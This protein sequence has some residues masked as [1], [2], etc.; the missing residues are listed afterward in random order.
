MA[1]EDRGQAPLS[2]FSDRNLKCVILC[3]G[4]GTRLLPISLEKQKGMI[5]LKEKP[6]IQHIIDYWS[7]FTDEFIFVVK[8]KK[9]EIMEY[10]GKTRLKAGFVEPPELRGI[11]DGIYQV[12]DLISDR[13]IVVLGDCIC[14]GEF[15]FP[16]YMEQGAGVWKTER[17]EDIKRSYSVLLKNGVIGGLEEKPKSPP[18]DLCG[19][20]FYFLDKRVFGYIE[21]TKPSSLRGEVE[22][23]DVIQNMISA[24]ERLSPVHFRGDYLN[25]TYAGDLELA[26]K[27]L[28]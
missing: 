16:D 24:G 13:F 6:I 1:I 10:V 15:I 18:N 26:L 4:K 14:K 23:T 17:V 3:G 11:A 22:I 2:W 12:K 19:M 27:I 5:R 21:N 25:I 9:E 28:K 20:G 8:Y 7:R